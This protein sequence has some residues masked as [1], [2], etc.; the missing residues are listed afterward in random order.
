MDH[1]DLSQ[2]KDQDLMVD[3]M[4]LDQEKDQMID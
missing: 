3:L 2:E 1:K 4:D